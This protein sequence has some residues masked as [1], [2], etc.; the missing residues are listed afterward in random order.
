MA[1]FV[2]YDVKLMYV[3]ITE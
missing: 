2:M 3:Q 1:R